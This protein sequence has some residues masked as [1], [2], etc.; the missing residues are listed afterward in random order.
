M[1][2][3]LWKFGIVWIFS[4]CQTESIKVVFVAYSRFLITYTLF[5][6]VNSLVTQHFAN[7]PWGSNNFL[8]SLLD[9]SD[10]LLTLLPLYYKI[11]SVII[12]QVNK[13]YQYAKKKC[14][15]GNFPSIPELCISFLHRH[16][17]LDIWQAIKDSA[18]TPCCPSNHCHY[19]YDTWQLILWK[20][21]KGKYCNA[22]QTSTDLHM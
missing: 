11:I 14:K 16:H 12:M 10:D 1:K 5:R 17:K 9:T 4:C 3:L 6:R 8:L 7:N 18:P 15:Q 20:V 2:Y 19:L 22:S 13:Q 21:I